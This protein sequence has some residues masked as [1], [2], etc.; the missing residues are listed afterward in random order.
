MG[1]AENGTPRVVFKKTS[2]WATLCAAG[3]AIGDHLCQAHSLLPGYSTT[4]LDPSSNFVYRNIAPLNLKRSGI[5][6]QKTKCQKWSL[7]HVFQEQFHLDR[8]L[9]RNVTI[10]CRVSR[11]REAHADARC[12]N[13]PS[14]RS[15]CQDQR[16][17]PGPTQGRSEENVE[18]CRIKVDC[19]D[20]TSK[21]K[22]YAK[23]LSEAKLMLNFNH[24]AHQ[25]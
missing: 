18:M 25:V 11:T 8:L 1:N 21:R 22:N 16:R 24:R 9:A 12:S 17:V 10:C 19:L 13:E 20:T 6:M 2:G 15:F 4:R 14:T 23:A 3:A 7:A 5:C